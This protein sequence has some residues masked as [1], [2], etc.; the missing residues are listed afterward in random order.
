MYGCFKIH[1]G[2][3]PLWVSFHILNISPFQY[4]SIKSYP[5]LSIS[6]S[7][8]FLLTN[9]FPWTTFPSCAS[10]VF[11]LHKLFS[12]NFSST[13]CFSS[14]HLYPLDYFC[15]SYY[16]YFYRLF[17]SQFIS[18]LSC[19][20]LDAYFLCVVIFLIPP[21][22]FSFTYFPQSSSFLLQSSFPF[23]KHVPT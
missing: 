21:V 20:P 14:N 19:T 5:H 11:S 4:F 13:D 3:F 23:R 8:L 10:S 9:I 2:I 6:P 15:H 12:P 17:S 1:L 7:E 22:F 18:P 16:L